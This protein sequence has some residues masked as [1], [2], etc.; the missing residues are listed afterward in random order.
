MLSFSMTI[1]RVSIIYPYLKTK[2]H[3]QI[4]QNK[5]VLNNISIQRNIP[6]QRN[7]IYESNHAELVSDTYS[8]P[9]PEADFEDCE[10]D[11]NLSLWQILR[12]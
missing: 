2:I 11:P 5:I 1:I 4:I 12:A 8:I 6:Q 3:E 10:T 9:E 7:H